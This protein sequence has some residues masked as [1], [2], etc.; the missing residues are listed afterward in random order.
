MELPVQQEEALSHMELQV[1]MLTP[2]IHNTYLA[3]CT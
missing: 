3:V 1:W 2:D